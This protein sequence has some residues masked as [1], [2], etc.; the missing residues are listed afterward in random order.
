MRCGNCGAELKPQ[1]RKELAFP[2][3]SM[4][5]CSERCL[6]VYVFRQQAIPEDVIKMHG[7]RTAPQN[8]GDRNCYSTFL[9]VSFRSW[10]ECGVAE[11]LVRTWQTQLFYEAHSLPLDNTHV[12]IPDFWLPEFGIW[13]EVKGEW[14]LGGKNKFERAQGILGSDRLLLIPDSYK[15]WFSRKRIQ[16]AG[17]QIASNSPSSTWR[18]K[19]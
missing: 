18:H 9:G 19:H 13:L 17:S 3:A 7:I 16:Y 10:F 4:R 2:V 8:W 5:F 12:Y 15:P 14:R 6:R 11:H 1:K